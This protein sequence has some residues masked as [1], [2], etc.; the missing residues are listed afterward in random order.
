[1][2]ACL[3]ICPSVKVKSVGLL[4]QVTNV[5]WHTQVAIL[6][7]KNT[8]ENI[9]LFKKLDIYA[10]IIF[11]CLIFREVQTL[12]PEIRNSAQIRFALE[13]YFALNSNN[14]IRFFRQVRRASFG[15]ACIMHRY[16]IQVRI[17]A[18]TSM[19]RGYRIGNKPAQVIVTIR[20]SGRQCTCFIV[21]IFVYMPGWPGTALSFRVL[22]LILLSACR[23]AVVS[24]GR[25]VFLRC[26]ICIW[27]SFTNTD[28]TFSLKADCVPAK[29]KCVQCESSCQ[30]IMYISNSHTQIYKKFLA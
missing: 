27:V 29:Q 6:R 15:N 2:P 9:Y 7:L 4:K 22:G 17:R 24:L 8:G 19:M 13:V 5:P 28:Y 3:P 16:F 11:I 14:Y 1:M 26:L 30:Y 21:G 25:V 18:L 20:F 10:I 12:R 23:M